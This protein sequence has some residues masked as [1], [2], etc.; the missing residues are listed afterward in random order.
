MWDM[1]T[2]EGNLDAEHLEP[3]TTLNV[4]LDVCKLNRFQI[5]A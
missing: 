5:T 3:I 4:R 1:L 2:N